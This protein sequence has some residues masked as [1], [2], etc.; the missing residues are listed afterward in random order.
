[1]DALE[2]TVA[3]A[4]QV[5]PE[6]VL[7]A[8]VIEQIFIDAFEAS[9]SMLADFKSWRLQG[10]SDFDPEAVRAESRRWLLADFDPWRADREDACDLA[11]FDPDAV[12]SMARERLDEA[13]EEEEQAKREGREPNR[14][15][16]NVRQV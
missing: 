9:D 11:G 7:W 2:E 4:Q 8:A 14:C 13:R 6:T 16:Y 12:R 10:D 5:S 3:A 15:R 1:M